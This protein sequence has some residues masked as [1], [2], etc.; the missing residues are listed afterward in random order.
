MVRDVGEADLPISSGAD[1]LPAVGRLSGREE[2]TGG[3]PPSVICHPS[4]PIPHLPSPIPHPPRPA[5]EARV[6]RRVHTDLTVEAEVSVGRE[7]AVLFG[8]SGA[9]KSTVLKLIA[10]L[11]RPDAGAV[12]LGDRVLFDRDRRVAVPLRDRRIGMI[13]QDD[14][15]FPHLSV[16]GNVGFGLAGWSRGEAEARVR[17]VARLCGA[18]GLLDRRPATLS[19]GE[20]QRVGLARALAP[21]PE[22]LLAD[23]PF[24]AL[25]LDGRDALVDRLR[26]VRRAEGIPVLYVTHSPAEAVALGDRLLLME[27]GR[28]V[29]EGRPLDVLA[30]RGGRSDWLGLRNVAAGVVTGHDPGSTRLAID[31]GPELV[32]PRLDRPVGSRVVAT[33]RADEILLARGP[34]GELSARNVI[35]GRVARVVTHGAEA[36]VVVA[37]G[38][39]EW[40]A[41]L[42]GSAVAA[43]EL[44]PGAEV[45][46]IIKARSCRVAADA[47]ADAP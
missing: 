28:I 4:S 9:G 33:V 2:V 8:P 35:A 43:L 42:V 18:E 14:L 44:Q 31:G 10:G 25:D 12:R 17:E 46:M 45:R 11:L 30:S 37:A 24:G 26:R 38:R 32:V 16:A 22:L 5:L 20:R 29:A 27:G 47:G 40:I 3:L 6:R 19:G 39:I 1:G 41:S 21:R 23:E 13:F 34:V 36:E 15:L 7:A